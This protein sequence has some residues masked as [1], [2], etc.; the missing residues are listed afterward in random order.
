MS[1]MNFKS[2]LW[3]LAFACAAVSCSDDL[4]NGPNNNEGNEL[5]GPTTYMKVT[6][7]QGVATKAAN[8]E[9]GDVDDG[10]VGEEYEYKVDDG[11]PRVL[12]E[13]IVNTKM[14]DVT[15]YDLLISYFTS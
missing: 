6:V 12:E 7:N 2:T 15:D 4:E 9:E 8:G 10:D 3:A 11:M 1:K 13:S 5:N 14:F